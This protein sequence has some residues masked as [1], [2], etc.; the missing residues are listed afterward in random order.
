LLT[1]VGIVPEAFMGTR[2]LEQTVDLWLPAD[3]RRRLVPFLSPDRAKPVSD[4]EDRAWTVIGRLRDGLGI[5]AAEAALRVTARNLQSR[6]PEVLRDITIA[7]RPGLRLESR[8]RAEFA[9]IFGL[10]LAAVFL[11]LLIACANVANLTLAR[12][13]GRSKEIAIRL[14]LGANRLRIVR[15]LLTETVLLAAIASTGGLVFA[16]WMLTAL[17]KT[18]PPE[19]AHVLLAGVTIADWRVA[20]L[21]FVVTSIVGIVAG[22]APAWQGANVPVIGA[23]KHGG[24]SGAKATRTR[25]VFVTAQVALAVVLLSASGLLVRALQ[26]AYAVRLGFETRG[27]MLASVD[28]PPPGE[29]PSP[30]GEGP[31]YRDDL[32]VRMDTELARQPGLLRASSAAQ[33]PFQEGGALVAQFTRIPAPKEPDAAA[34]TVLQNLVGPA[35]FETLG[36]SMRAGR[37]FGLRDTSQSEP[38]VIVNEALAKRRWPNENPVGTSIR[39]DHER[40]TR[41]VVGVAAQAQHI[42]FAGRYAEG[43]YVPLTQVSRFPRWTLLFRPRGDVPSAIEAVQRALDAVGPNLPLYDARPMEE[44]IA[45]SVFPQRIMAIVTGTFGLFAL[46]LTA[47][48]LAAA[49]SFVVAQRTNEIGIRMALGAQGPQVMGLVMRGTLTVA[50]IGAAIGLALSAAVA[51]LLNSQFTGFR[52]MDPIVPL[53]VCMLLTA[54][55]LTAAILPARRASRVDPLAALRAE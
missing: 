3:A 46:L 35:Y 5:Q 13:L 51:A 40:T 7:L 34:S 26:E 27:L 12:T 19:A 24:T 22:L 47:A 48:G 1:I 32:G 18:M 20:T 6:H 11:V 25:L 49:I 29:G 15:Q 23:I 54:V 9:T 38:V 28:P 55:T 14:S 8:E 4:I 45:R 31:S 41:T 44:H 30:P 36:L 2:Q 52:V 10:I 43:L 39:L 53:A 16:R 42:G 17:G 21:L 37:G 50:A 33:P